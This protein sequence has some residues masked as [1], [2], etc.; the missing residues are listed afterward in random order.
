MSDFREMLF[1]KTIEPKNW[2]ELQAKDE[3]MQKEI[4]DQ[5][6]EVGMSR[7]DDDDYQNTGM[8]RSDFYSGST[9]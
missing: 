3:A 8:S 6:E 7:S 9:Y 4:D 1:S 5:L 2:Q